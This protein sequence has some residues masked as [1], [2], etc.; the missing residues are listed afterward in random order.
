MAGRLTTHVI[1]TAQGRPA[2]FMAIELWLVN[3]QGGDRTFLKAVRTNTEGRTDEPL[4]VDAELKSGYYE[5]VFAV[6]D[7]FARQEVVKSEQP[8]LGEVPI[9]F[10]ISDPD[11]H[12][13]IPL[14]VSP[15]SYS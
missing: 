3:A 4:L 1:D 12:Y 15:W 6:G 5:L 11:S 13:H 14:L 10:G 8:F 2:V 9:R 7:Y